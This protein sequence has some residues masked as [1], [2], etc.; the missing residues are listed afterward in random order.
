MGNQ[1]IPIE[2]FHGLLRDL[3]LWDL[4]VPGDDE[5]DEAGS[6]RLVPQAQQ[7]LTELAAAQKPWPADRTVYV[8]RRCSSCGLRQLTWLR[9]GAYLCSRCW[10]SQVTRDRDQPT[11]LTTLSPIS[12]RRP[13]WAPH[14][15]Q[16]IA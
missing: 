13:W 10:E 5:G 2:T 9:E 1:Q 6:W 14:R 3:L 11:P 7:R 16:R 12:A 4:V 8:D 15:R